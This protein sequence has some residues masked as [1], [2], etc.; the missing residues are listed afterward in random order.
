LKDDQGEL[1]VM[2]IA[3]IPERAPGAATMLALGCTE[4][5]MGPKAQIGDFESVV[6]VG[7]N[8]QK[9][10]QYTVTRDA[11]I[12]LAK[13][14][15]YS[16]LLARGMFDESL[17]IY[18]VQS[19]KGP[20]EW[21][22]I[23]KE[24][25]DRDQAAGGAQ[26]WEKRVQVKAP[27]RLLKLD[28]SQARQFGLARE[29]V[30]DFPDLCRKYG[31]KNVPDM[32]YD[33]LYR[34]AEFLG[35]PVTAVFLIMIGIACL[36]LELKLPGVSLPGVIAAVC[37]F[38]YFWA[39]SQLTGQITT[40]AI[41]LFLLG[42]VLI[43]LEI[44]LLP[45]SVI[46]GLSG[47]VLVVLSLALATL[48]KKP[49]TQQE[50]FSFGQTLG[51]VG[52]GLGGAVALAFLTAWYLPSIPYASRLILKPPGESPDGVEPEDALANAGSAAMLDLAGLLG[53][54]GV[55][56]TTLRPAGLA[57]FGDDYV[58]VVTEGNFIEAGGRIQ[59]IEIEGNRVVVKEV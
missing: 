7:R 21:K 35:H 16:P 1:S 36:I 11:L 54:I 9:P 49:E 41:L 26:K 48:E 18:E 6:G 30:D 46:M 8:R 24:D 44:F 47:V 25:L 27:G 20:A 42:L 39:Q 13:E 34:L 22:L 33:F 29:I 12:E 38:L 2:T 56:A 28:A 52:V 19:K 55:A 14:Q 59:V 45:G 4:I 37:F 51:A 10:E 50:W 5:T 31:L 58:D 15:G 17:A 23:D 57:K 53:A 3:Y 40:L 43:G 32:G